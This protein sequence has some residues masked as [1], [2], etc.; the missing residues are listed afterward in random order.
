MQLSEIKPCLPIIG[1]AFE[2]GLHCVAH[3]RLV[4]GL[5]VQLGH[6]EKGV[7]RRVLREAFEA[8]VKRLAHVI[9][10]LRPLIGLRHLE[11]DNR[12]E[13][14]VLQHAAHQVVEL[15]HLAGITIELG[16][17]ERFVSG[18]LT[19]RARV[20]LLE[21]G[22]LL[23]Q[24]L[25]SIDLIKEVLHLGISRVHFAELGDELP[26]F[27]ELTGSHV[28][29]RR[30]DIRFRAQGIEHTGLAE[31]GFRLLLEAAIGVESGD[32]AT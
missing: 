2:I 1:S 17:L 31:R 6:I 15:T 5:A 26:G 10:T 28:H 7:W 3:T 13:P 23:V 20:L 29:L 4:L 8:E 30:D 9:R 24:T 14:L 12:W 18:E 32:R 21:V 22:D 25:D 19:A 11:V 16:K 27:A